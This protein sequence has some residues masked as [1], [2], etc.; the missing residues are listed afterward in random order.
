MR[1]WVAAIMLLLAAS[2]QGIAASSSAPPA[3]AISP[4]D[5]HAGC[6]R[7]DLRRCVISLGS[8]FWFQ[9]ELVAA[10]IAR[11]NELDVNGKPA[12]ERRRI[13]VAA[14]LPNDQTMF[15]L[16]LTLPPQAPNDEVAKVTLMPPRDPDLAH[17]ASEYDR[18]LLYDVVSVVLGN[19]CPSLDKM[20]L[21]RF[22]ENSIKPLE[23][24][25]IETRTE[26]QYHWLRSRVDVGPLPFCGAMFS[27]HRDADWIG[28]RLGIPGPDEAIVG[29]S[30][31]KG[32]L[33]ID[34]E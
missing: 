15:G 18:T 27:I 34:I 20:A 25:K 2:A 4:E 13:V 30:L 19:R 33:T 14:R 12:L 10:Q 31:L 29:R 7:T 11:R 9:M 21:Y 24:P 28:P 8:A 1:A 16:T 22:Y 26:G 32:R 23:T 5:A 17:T 6:V 3:P